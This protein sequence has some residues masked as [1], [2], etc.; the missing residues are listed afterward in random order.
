MNKELTKEDFKIFSDYG[1]LN[2]KGKDAYIEV[3]NMNK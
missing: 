1:Y 3:L 2:S